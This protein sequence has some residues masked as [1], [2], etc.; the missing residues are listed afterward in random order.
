MNKYYMK[1]LLK[2]KTKRTVQLKFLL[3]LMITLSQYYLSEED[4][5][6]FAFSNDTNNR[7]A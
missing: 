2:G 1:F 3:Y 7:R 5:H 4:V 6:L